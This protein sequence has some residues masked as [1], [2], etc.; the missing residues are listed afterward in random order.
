MVVANVFVD[1]SHGTGFQAVMFG[2]PNKQLFNHVQNHYHQYTNALGESARRWWNEATGV[3]ERT[4]Y[5]QLE[6][7]VRAY[8]RHYDEIWRTD[9]IR[10]LNTIAEVQTAPDLMH[11]WIMAEPTIRR[12]YHEGMA[13]GYHGTY[14]DNYEGL[15]GVD[16]YE[17]RRVMHGVVIPNSDNEGWSASQYIEHVWDADDY[18]EIDDQTSILTTWDTIKSHLETRENDDDPTSKWNSSLG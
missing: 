4:S 15:V 1:D 8:R 10:P 7:R 14:V 3:F 12:M 11:R 9:A 13:E 5:E 2:G 18:L 16:H 17:Y 6:R